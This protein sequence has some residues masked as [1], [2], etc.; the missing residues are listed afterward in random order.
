MCGG[1]TSGEKAA[2]RIRVGATLVQLETGLMERDHAYITN[3]HEYTIKNTFRMIDDDIKVTPFNLNLKRGR[4][5][6]HKQDDGDTVF[7]T[8]LRR[9]CF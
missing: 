9:I 4:E 8:H 5:E 1:V 3:V 2:Q 7:N 6:S